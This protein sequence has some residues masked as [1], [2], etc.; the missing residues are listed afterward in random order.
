MEQMKCKWLS[1][2][3]FEICTNADCDYRAD[4][5]PCTKYPNVCRYSELAEENKDELED[6]RRE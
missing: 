2:D 5:C 6:K 1:D 4:Y 3:F